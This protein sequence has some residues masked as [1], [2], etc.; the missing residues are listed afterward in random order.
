M[1]L[2]RELHKSDDAPKLV[3][4]PTETKRRCKKQEKL[5]PFLS[6]RH[7]EKFA[8]FK[9]S[10]LAPLSLC[11]APAGIWLQQERSKS[12]SCVDWLNASSRSA[13]PSASLLKHL[14]CFVRINLLKGCWE[15][16]KCRYTIHLKPMQVNSNSYDKFT[17]LTMLLKSNNFQRRQKRRCKKQEKLQPF[18]SARH[19]ENFASFKLSHLAPLSLC[20]APAGI[21]LQQERSKSSSCVDWLRASNKSAAPA[22]PCVWLLKHLQCFARI[23]LL[24]GCWEGEKCRYTIHLKPMQ[25]NSNSYENFTNLTMLLKSNNFQQRQLHTGIKQE[26]L[27]P[28]LSARHRPKSAFFKLSHLAP[29]SFCHAA[30]GIR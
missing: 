8:F 28:F 14:Q 1:Q 15:G 26:N 20:H 29:C 4:L 23:T 16:E 21:W 9:L 13:A 6:A 19:S 2:I 17:N 30:A 27:Q 3:Q 24:K 18:L 25:V 5:Q 12:S 11:H 7:W 22:A 10:H